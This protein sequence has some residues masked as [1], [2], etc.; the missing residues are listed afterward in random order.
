MEILK[1]EQIFFSS[2]QHS[3]ARR[4]GKMCENSVM[5]SYSWNEGKYLK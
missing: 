5:K 3:T 1:S 2:S 4:G